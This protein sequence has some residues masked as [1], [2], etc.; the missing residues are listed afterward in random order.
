MSMFT[1][2]NVLYFRFK[3]HFRRVSGVWF[4]QKFVHEVTPG[5]RL[6]E[7]QGGIYLRHTWP[8]RHLRWKSKVK[9]IWDKNS[10]VPRVVSKGKEMA[11]LFGQ[12]GANQS[13]AILQKIGDDQKIDLYLINFVF[14]TWHFSIGQPDIGCIFFRNCWWKFLLEVKFQRTNDIFVID[15]KPLRRRPLHWER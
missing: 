15:P 5:L 10:K 14:K 11:H 9:Q 3:S 7:P 12:D 4:P 6:V 13:F 2:T 1:P 8:G